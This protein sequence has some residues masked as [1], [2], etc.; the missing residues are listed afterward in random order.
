[1]P[2]LTTIAKID[3]FK[4]QLNKDI[5]MLLNLCGSKKTSQSPENT[6]KNDVFLTSN[7]KSRVIP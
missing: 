5:F 2:N 1:M 3:K 6:G 4:N 7:W